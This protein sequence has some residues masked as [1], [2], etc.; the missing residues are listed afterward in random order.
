[1]GSLWK[2]EGLAL[3]KPRVHCTR[4]ATKA[5]EDTLKESG[6]FENIQPSTLERKTVTKQIMSNF[7][8]LV[9]SLD[10]AFLNYD[11]GETNKM[12]FSK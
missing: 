4:L 7:C 2:N 6:I 8:L 1:V 9:C 12:H 10:Y 5:L 3:V 11:E